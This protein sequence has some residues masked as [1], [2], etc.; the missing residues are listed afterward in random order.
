VKTALLRLLSRLGL[1]LPVFRGWERVRTLGVKTVAV[2]PDGLPFPTPELMIRV[3]GT[4]DTG[5]F[6]EG[7]QLAE[8][9]IRA[10]LERAGAPIGS[11]EAIL[12]FGCGCGR[13]LR[14]WHGVDARICGSDLSDPAV[15]WCRAHLPFVE[16]GVNA[17]EPPLT[18]RDASFDLVYALSVLTHLPVATQLAWRDE[19]GRVLRPG[20]HLLLTLC[21]DAYVEKLRGEERRIYANGECVVRWA[22]VA[23]ANLCSAFHPPAFVRDRLADGW[24]LVEHV[25]RGAL[26]KPGAGPH[27]PAQAEFVGAGPDA[28]GGSAECARARRPPL[29]LRR[30]RRVVRVLVLHPMTEGALHGRVG[31]EVLRQPPPLATRQ[32][33][34]MK[35][36]H[37]AARRYREGE[38]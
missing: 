8:E 15:K 29:R 34:L 18:Y 24:E 2:G 32:G 1:L 38:R 13:V 27:R 3:A 21:G 23:G 31:R 22:E 6:I 10:A 37:H 36:V 4:V 19:L 28:P 9:S 17:L 25:P 12:D 16:A 35:R 7:G 11:L 5:W 30:A 14:R 20:G 26:G 33:P